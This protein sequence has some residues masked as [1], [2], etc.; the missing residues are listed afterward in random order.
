[1]LNTAAL[2]AW[3]LK[4]E[5]RRWDW[6]KEVAVVTGGCSGIGEVVVKG[7]MKKGVKVAVIDIQPLPDSLKNCT[8]GE[9][10]HIEYIQGTH[11]R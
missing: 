2:N 4:S 3:R 10:G 6:K 7:L 5:K 9:R 11:D 1:M 8:C